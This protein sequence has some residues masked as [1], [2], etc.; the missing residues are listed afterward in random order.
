[1]FPLFLREM[2]SR[3]RH[4]AMEAPTISQ[5]VENPRGM[6]VKTEELRGERNRSSFRIF[7][8]RE[9][10][11]ARSALR[12]FPS[13][14]TLSQR[15]RGISCEET[16]KS[17]LVRAAEAGYEFAASTTSSARILLH[18]RGC[19][20]LLIASYRGRIATD[21]IARATRESALDKDTRASRCCSAGRCL[22]RRRRKP[23]A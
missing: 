17:Y 18:A 8:D 14:E 22:S 19:K 3:E 16:A 20:E 15:V 7:A 4:F 12:I 10:S 1:M 9:S 5:F 23:R 11:I 6:P 13:R 2:C 21:V